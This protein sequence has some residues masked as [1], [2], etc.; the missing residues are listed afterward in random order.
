MMWF[1]AMNGGGLQVYDIALVGSAGFLGSAIGATLRSRGHRTH[2]FTRAAPIFDGRRLAPIA[3]DV[4][5]II[6]AA[7]AVS[8]TVAA[9]RPDVVE[10]ELAEFRNAVNAVQRL[11]SPPRMLLL[12]SGGTVYGPPASAPYVESDAP[13]PSNKYG[14]YKLAEERIVLDAIADSV[15]LRVSN[16]YGP[17]QRGARGQGVL[18]VWMRS[19]LAG[20]P[21]RIHGSG[22]VARDY[23]YVDDVAEAVAAA[24][25][26]ERPPRVVNV[27]S[28]R[29]TSLDELAA[30]FA[31]VT[32]DVEVRIERLPSR[33]VD[34]P[35]TWLDV[36][37]ATSQLDW[38]A[39][40]DLEEGLTAMWE[41]MRAQ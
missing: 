1:R 7:G 33:G 41:W 25:G 8:P 9:A 5:V 13:S 11:D 21:I 15:V 22:A 28:G 40:V 12:S 4:S 38:R 26:C 16:A 27:G 32:G 10:V 18:A 6:W 35:S 29:A 36:G 3:N 39:G 31:K 23:V 19:L 24:V 37:L 17:G 20:E 34:A 2:G 14:E 30:T